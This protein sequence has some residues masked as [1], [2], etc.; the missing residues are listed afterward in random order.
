MSA[1][2][3]IMGVAYLLTGLGITVG[4]HRLFTHRAFKTSKAGIFI[5]AVLGSA[6]V[7]GPVIEW[8]A[9][10]RQHHQFSD[11][12]GDPHTPH[13]HG[14]GLMGALKGLY[15]AHL[16]WLFAHTEC[17][18]EERYCPDLRKEPILRFVHKT[19]FLWVVLGLAIPFFFG[20]VLGGAIQDGLTALLWG[21]AVRLFLLHHFTF[22]I[23]SLCHFFGKRTYETTDHST[24]LFWLAPFTLGEAWHNNHHAF[25]TS[26]H[27]GLRWWQL[28]IAG[29]LITGLEKC[30]LVWDVVKISPEHQARKLLA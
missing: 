3:T 10:H 21:G 28:D 17:G 2:H 27:H 18:D 4:Y 9:N 8:A 25:P 16:G 20:W 15:H 6:A 22:S 14:S 12:E 7:E 29:L 30:H 13:G 24:N 5:F 26:A 23:N 19:F 1:H 11:H